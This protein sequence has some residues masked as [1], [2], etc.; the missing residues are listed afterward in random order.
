M[1]NLFTQ[2][3]AKPTKTAISKVEDI[4]V[5]TPGLEILAQIDSLEKQLDA[6]KKTALRPFIQ[7]FMITQFMMNRGENYKGEEGSATASLE[8]RKRASNS[9]LNEAEI[10]IL[11]QY[12]IPMV[13]VEGDFKLNVVGLTAKK[14]AQVS[15]AIESIRGLPEDFITFDASKERTIVADDSLA[16]VFKLNDQETIRKL[17]PIVGIFAIKPKTSSTMNEVM[18]AVTELVCPKKEK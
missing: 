17:I 7:E 12:D 3:K 6:L 2:A 11:T 13:R 16:T 1:T 5:K 8:L 18:E 4:R 9:G 15:E 10:E 14:L